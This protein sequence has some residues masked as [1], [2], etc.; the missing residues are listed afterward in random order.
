M[1]EGYIIKNKNSPS[2][3]KSP[4]NSY[5]MVQKFLLSLPPE[6]RCAP[7]CLARKDY[8]SNVCLTPLPLQET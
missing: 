6:Y 5:K 7:P 2:K 1:W 8:Y 3:N 4:M